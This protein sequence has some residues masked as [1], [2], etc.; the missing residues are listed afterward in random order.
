MSERTPGD[1]AP[2]AVIAFILPG[3]GH[4]LPIASLIQELDAPGGVAIAAEVPERSALRDRVVADGFAFISIPTITTSKRSERPLRALARLLRTR[5]APRAAAHGTTPIGLPSLRARFAFAL[6]TQ[7][8]PLPHPSPAA[9]AALGAILDATQPRLILADY[10]SPWFGVLAAERAVPYLRYTICPVGAVQAGRPVAPAGLD[11]ALPGA[12]RTV[13]RV[14]LRARRVRR[15]QADRTWRATRARH[16]SGRVEATEAEPLGTV[17]FT[18]RALDDYP[19]CPQDA[20]A[21]VGASLYRLD[22]EATPDGERDTILVTWGSWP[23]AGDAEVLLRLAPALVERAETHRVVVQTGDPDLQ[24]RLREASSRLVA[25]DP[26]PVPLWDEYRRSRLVIGAGGYG[27]IIESLCFGSPVLTVPLM[28]ADR[29]ETGQRLIQ[30]G[31]GLTLDRYTFEPADAATAIGRLLDE[32]GF[33]ER[34]R[35]VGA[36]LRDRQARNRLLDQLRHALAD[37]PTP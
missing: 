17:A 27:T 14:I 15:W 20:Y 16:Q 9:G 29:L 23:G 21:Y 30:S 4:Y 12:Q 31:A 3:I 37:G 33:V 7:V 11:P 25:V 5:I 19:Q 28:A 24:A 1:P 35:A 2:A 10:D 26:T 32:P 18:A 8:L 6:G 22:G 13:N 34:A 36:E